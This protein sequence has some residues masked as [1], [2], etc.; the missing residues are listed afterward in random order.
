MVLAVP[1][2]LAPRFRLELSYKGLVPRLEVTSELI[3]AHSR[4]RE[5]GVRMGIV[6]T[7]H[8]PASLSPHFPTWLLT[9]WSR[10]NHG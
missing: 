9:P 1:D 4:V 10:L 5:H 3:T 8:M 2:P 6:M 7:A